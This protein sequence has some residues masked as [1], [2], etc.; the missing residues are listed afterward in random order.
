[1]CVYIHDALSTYVYVCVCNT[2][3]QGSV[4]GNSVDS[5]TVK[6]TEARKGDNLSKH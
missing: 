3:L 5:G 2:A 4:K 1:V 6:S